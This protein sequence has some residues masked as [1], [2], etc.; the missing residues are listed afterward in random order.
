MAMHILH[1]KQISTFPYRRQD[2]AGL[3]VC[4]TWVSPDCRWGLCCPSVCVLIFVCICFVS[5]IRCCLCQLI[6]QSI[7]SELYLTITFIFSG[8]S[9][10]TQSHS[11]DTLVEVS[12]S[13]WFEYGRKRVLRRSGE[14]YND[15]C[16]IERDSWETQTAW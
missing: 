12:L 11:I 1:F 6:S 4:V 9:S 10:K 5:C 16:S 8:V 3:I 2:F 14:R 13:H 7:F 15:A